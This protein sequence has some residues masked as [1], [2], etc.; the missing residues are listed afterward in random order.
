ME[1]V[2]SLFT[3]VSALLRFQAEAAFLL[4]IVTGSA[5][6]AGLAVVLVVLLAAASYRALNLAAGFLETP[7]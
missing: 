5:A 2:R 4:L 6:A 7:Q 1:K 3:P